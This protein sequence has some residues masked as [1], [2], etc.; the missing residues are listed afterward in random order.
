MDDFPEQANV[1]TFKFAVSL[2]FEPVLPEGAALGGSPFPEDVVAST[3]LI[4]KQGMDSRPLS[5]KSK[6]PIHQFRC[7]SCTRRFSAF[8][9]RLQIHGLTQFRPRVTGW[10]G[11]VMVSTFCVRR[12]ADRTQTQAQPLPTHSRLPVSLSTFKYTVSLNF[13][14]V[15]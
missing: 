6:L 11:T 15:L 10:N 4:P 1:L 5:M 14:L 2:N 7:W 12:H 8:S 13:E 3:E 9:G